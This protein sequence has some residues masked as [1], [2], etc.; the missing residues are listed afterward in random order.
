VPRTTQSR[1]S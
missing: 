1:K